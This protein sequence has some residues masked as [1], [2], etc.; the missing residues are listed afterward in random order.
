MNQSRVRRALLSLNGWQIK[1][2]GIQYIFAAVTDQDMR[3]IARPFLEARMVRSERLKLLRNPLWIKL[4]TPICS[5]LGR[6]NLDRLILKHMA[7]WVVSQIANI[8][9]GALGDGLE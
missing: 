8:N 5:L 4:Q 7:T 2:K 1:P 3:V 9:S 6:L